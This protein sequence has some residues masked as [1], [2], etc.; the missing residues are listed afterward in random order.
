MSVVDTVPCAGI[1]GQDGPVSGA[2]GVGAEA[3]ASG[4]GARIAE[5][6]G[7]VIAAGDFEAIEQGETIFAGAVR[8]WVGRK[9]WKSAFWRLYFVGVVRRILSRSF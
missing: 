5:K 2:G 8:R 1:I 6:R 7:T 4:S 9:K 3:S